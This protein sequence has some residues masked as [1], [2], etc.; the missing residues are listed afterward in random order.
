MSSAEVR[1]FIQRR[2]VV[3]E[4]VKEVSLC[5]YRTFRP[6]LL[7]TN[8]V[9]AELYRALCIVI[10]VEV[11]GD[12][13]RLM[14]EWHSGLRHCISVLEA[15]LQTLVRSQAVSQPAVIWSLIV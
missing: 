3:K 9:N 15:S 2:A 1:A 7:S 8:H 5:L 12:A 14:Y 4:V 13:L 6:H 10:K 11:H